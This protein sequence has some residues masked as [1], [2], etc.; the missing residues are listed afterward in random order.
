MAALTLKLV[1]RYILKQL[2]DYFLLGV[3]VFTLIAFFSDTLLNFIREIQKYGIPFSTLLTMVGLQLPKSVAFVL[4]ASAFLAVLM[5]YN[6]LNNNFEVISFRMNGIS[7]WRLTVPALILGLFTSVVAYGLNDYIVP[8]CN[9]KTEQMKQQVIRSGSLPPNGTSFM[10]RTYDDKH[11]LVQLIYISQYH[12]QKLGDSTILDLSKPDVMQIVQARSGTWSPARGW[13]LK[14]ANIYLVSKDT[15]HSSAGHSDIFN[16]RGLMGNR[17]EAQEQQER[18]RRVQEGIDIRTNEQNF[19]QVWQLIQKRTA[20]GKRVARSNYLD[21][22]E[23]ITWP[24]GALVLVLSAVPLA[25]SPPR[26]GNSR[27]FIF[28]I[29]VLGL[30]YELY[31]VFQG[32]GRHQ[33]WDLGGLLTLPTYL[34][35]VSWAPFII[36]TVIGVLL[37]RRKSY[38]L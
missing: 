12:G 38:V 33:F 5:V 17:Q 35:M 15:E 21:L 22:W 11:N 36:M 14:N 34:A 7:L 24:L 3:V 30:F 9:A 19:A 26:A 37:L 16:V 25:L 4:P 31:T 10:Y 20:L 8:W 27:G 2:V 32:I 29:A 23:K 28:A 6:Q 13:A 1:D 18:L